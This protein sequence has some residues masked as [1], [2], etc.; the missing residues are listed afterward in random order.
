MIRCSMSAFLCTWLAQKYSFEYRD[1]QW[2]SALSQDCTGHEG[3]HE[4]IP[5]EAIVPDYEAAVLRTR[6]PAPSQRP[7]ET[8]VKEYPASREPS[9]PLPGN[10]AATYGLAADLALI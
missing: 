6:P 3:L 5:I 2:Q 8:H 1:A 9:V 10:L 4:T 7:M